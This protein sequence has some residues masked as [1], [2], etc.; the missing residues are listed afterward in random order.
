[1]KNNIR[2]LFGVVFLFSIT[3]SCG[4]TNKSDNLNY[5]DANVS[6]SYPKKLEKAPDEIISSFR[7][8]L[9]SQQNVYTG[10]V[11][12]L[13]I[14]VLESSNYTMLV[15]DKANVSDILTIDS[16][17]NQRK[18]TDKDALE[19]GYLT[20]LNALE[21]KKINGILM[22]IEDFHANTGSNSGR[23]YSM[24]TIVNS[25]IYEFTV[26]GLNNNDFSTY[27]SYLDKIIESF[28]LIE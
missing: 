12:E 14:F 28:I 22:L 24:R 5:K 15:F 25:V 19:A 4:Q 2:F 13:E 27:K 18:Q 10:K 17:L 6:F 16:L 23:S 20:K 9:E 7:Q 8:Q 21:I 11:L 26:A 3:T 1:M